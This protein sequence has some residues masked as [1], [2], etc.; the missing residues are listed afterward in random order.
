MTAGIPDEG[1]LPLS[2]EMR[3]DAVCRRFEKAWKAA[4][5][6]GSR[7]R[8]KDYLPAVNETERWP[9]L[10]ELLLLELHYRRGETPS[11]EEYGGRYPDYAERII[12]LFRE[13][14]SAEAAQQASDQSDLNATE[15][16]SERPRPGPGQRQSPT[17]GA[18]PSIPGYD[19]L[20]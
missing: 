10:R 1:S 2:A 12:V 8:I 20:G 5:A 6:G 17:R 3:I 15:T 7:P 18:L 4:S 14:T 19:I 13:Q 9:L 16:I 11:A